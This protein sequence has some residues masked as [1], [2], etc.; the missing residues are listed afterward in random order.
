V[1]PPTRLINAALTRHGYELRPLVPAPRRA[2]ER[3]A[4]VARG[5]TI[6]E[7]HRAQS[8]ESVAALRRRYH[9]PVFGRVDTWT[10][11]ERLA[12]CLDP[13]DGLLGCTSQLVHVLQILDMMES[14]GVTDPH[15]LAAAVVHDVGKLLLLVDEAPENV[16]C[17]NEPIGEY[18]P[19]AGLDNCVLQWNHD[20][21]AFTRLSGEVPAAVAWL[22]RY[23]SVVFERCE[24]L[25]DARDRAWAEQYLRPFR[26]Y[27]QGSKSQH[28]I[29]KAR[30]ADYRDRLEGV[31]PRT[32]LF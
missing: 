8:L 22:V 21:F 18:P 19:G 29:P 25:M 23:H 27:D 28:V 30:L 31:L 32:I 7:A 24:S 2:Q 3:A 26:R 4:F 16:V 11:V 5:R 6:R 13:T 9:A 12:N 10:L 1:R 15:L 20:E 17:L 14:E